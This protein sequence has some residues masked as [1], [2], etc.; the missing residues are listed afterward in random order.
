M[1]KC[2]FQFQFPMSAEE[3]IRKVGQAI[4]RAGG[5]LDGDGQSGFYTVPTPVGTIEGSYAVKDQTIHI[6]VLDKPIY[7]PCALI[8]KTLHQIVRQEGS[9]YSSS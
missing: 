6:D 8:E 5:E 7:V 2:S 3:L 9:R 1:A 4:R